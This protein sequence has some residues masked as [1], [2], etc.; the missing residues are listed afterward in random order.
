MSSINRAESAYWLKWFD[1]LRLEQVKINGEELPATPP[2]TAEGGVK[3]PIS[4]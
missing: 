3:L 1:G 4:S 2:P